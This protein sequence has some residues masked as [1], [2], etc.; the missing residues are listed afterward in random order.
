MCYT[1]EQATQL[2]EEV[3][4]HNAVFQVGLQRRANP[5]YRQAA[6][7]I[8]SG[9]LGQIGAVKCQWHRNNDWRRPVPVEKGNKEWK[10][11]EHHINWRL[12]KALFSWADD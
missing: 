5:I 7:M 3:K 4:K 11:L 6:S 2:A 9:M 8:E 10:R 12:Y 1:I